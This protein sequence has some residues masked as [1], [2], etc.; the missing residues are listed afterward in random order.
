MREI[1]RRAIEESGIPAAVLME[2]AGKAVADLVE[3]RVSRSCPVVVVCGPGNNGGDGFVAARLLC[4]RGFEVDVLEVARGRGAPGPAVENRDRLEGMDLD[5]VA[6][7]KRR[8]MAAIV[9]ALYGIGL[10]RPLAGRDKDLVLEINALDPRWF[11]VVSVDIPSG[12]DADTGRVLGA[13]VKASATVTFGL[14]K[15][16]FR[17]ASARPC[18]GEVVVAGIGIPPSL[19]GS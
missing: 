14:P 5:F 8:P 17:S 18:L 6:R 16:G 9:D 3:E 15:A 12:L 1:E 2:N 13:A 10:S 7:L 19:L 11:P 4:E